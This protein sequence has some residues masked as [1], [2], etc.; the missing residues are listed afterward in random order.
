LGLG[1]QYG[2]FHQRWEH[3]KLDHFDDNGQFNNIF[4]FVGGINSTASVNG[5]TSQCSDNDNA[6]YIRI[7]HNSL[8]CCP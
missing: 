8:C 4:K 2:Q 1:Q 6:G 5:S 3:N 7:Q